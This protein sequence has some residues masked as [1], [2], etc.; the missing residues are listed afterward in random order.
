MNISIYSC[1]EEI[2]FIPLQK[3]CLRLQTCSCLIFDRCAKEYTGI[4][5][6]IV[7]E[8]SWTFFFIC[9]CQGSLT[10]LIGK[11]SGDPLSWWGG[12]SGR[13]RSE[14]WSRNRR[15]R[16]GWV[17]SNRS[18]RLCSVCCSSPVLSV[19]YG[20]NCCPPGA[21]EAYKSCRFFANHYFFHI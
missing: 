18:P 6:C 8:Y 10:T 4:Y 15:G 7:M 21:L 17:A 20:S 5:I 12:T 11:W 3:V 9:R 16:P 13:M 14:S 1:R 19:L 2:K